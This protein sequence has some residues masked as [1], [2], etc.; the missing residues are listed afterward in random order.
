[1]AAGEGKRN[2]W[3]Y[4]QKVSKNPHFLEL[5]E[6]VKSFMG[7]ESCKKSFYPHKNQKRRAF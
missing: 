2:D 7:T 6:D 5:L 1:M 4:G 3:V